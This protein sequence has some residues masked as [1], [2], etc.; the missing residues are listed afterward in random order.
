MGLV[1][2]GVLIAMS[3]V[4]VPAGAVVVIW[5]SDTTV[6]EVA[7]VA[8][9]V[10]EAAAVNPV[11]VI[12]TVVPGGPDAGLTP[13]TEGAG[14]GAAVI[15]NWS[16]VTTGLVPPGV[17]TVTS[18]TPVGA[19]VGTVVVICVSETTVKLLAAVEPQATPVATVN[20][21]PTRRGC[22]CRR[23]GW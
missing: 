13:D 23:R 14:G 3:M 16:A 22:R 5:V 10:T 8:P 11:P 19:P 15:V 7:G 17:V 21:V 1:P 9:K 18:T 20:P 6:N 2:P 12:V 4:P